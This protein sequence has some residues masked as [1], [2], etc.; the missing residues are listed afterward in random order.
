MITVKKE[1]RDDILSGE[2]LIEKSPIT[3]KGDQIFIILLETSMLFLSIRLHT[4]N[5]KI[6]LI[7]APKPIPPTLVRSKIGSKEALKSNKVNIV[8][9]K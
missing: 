9:E 1:R 3:M 7:T 5:T 4:H 8:C 2:I 6:K